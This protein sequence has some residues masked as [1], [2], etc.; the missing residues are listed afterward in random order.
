MVGPRGAKISAFLFQIGS[1]KSVSA[2]REDTS[3]LHSFYSK[4]VR[5]K[6]KRW[7]HPHGC[8]GSFYSKLVRL[9]ALRTFLLQR[10]IRTFLFQIGSIKRFLEKNDLILLWKFLFQIGSIKRTT[11]HKFQSLEEIVSIPNWFD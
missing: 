8:H 5:L 1:I 11:V 2:H 4:L 3:K 9:K 10:G 6:D 7:N